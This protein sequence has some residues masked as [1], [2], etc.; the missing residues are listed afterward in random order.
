MR[1]YVIRIAYNKVAQAEDRPSPIG[2]DSF[3]EAKKAFHSYLAQNIMGDTIGWYLCMVINKE[4]RTL[5]Q[6]KWEG[7]WMPEPEENSEPE[8]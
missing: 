5:L 1:Y 7:A 6:E 2:Y 8:E 3:D 4:G